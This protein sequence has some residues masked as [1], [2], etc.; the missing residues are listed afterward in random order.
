MTRKMIRFLDAA[1]VTIA[2]IFSTVGSRILAADEYPIRPITLVVPM[3]SGASTDIVARML[4]QE[5][6]GRLGKPV[7][8]ENKTGA[9][10]TI[11]TNY[12]ATSKPDGYTLLMVGSSFAANATI[13]KSLPYNVRTDFVPIAMVAEIP[14]ALLVNN[15][16][17]IATT[18]DLIAYAKKNPNKLNMATAGIGTPHHLFGELFS[19]MAGIKLT[20]VPYRGSLPGLNDVLSGSV[21]LMFCDLPPAKGMLESGKI[22]ALGVTSS[23]RVP[24]LPAVP[25]IGERDVPN[26][27]AVAWFTLLAPARTP[28]AV[29]ERLH[30][31]IKVIL[32]EQEMKDR[33][34]RMSLAPMRS[35]SLSEMQAFMNSEINR[36]GEVV[37]NAGIA[38]SQ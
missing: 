38:F 14:F 5:L 28:P 12:V 33:I 15:D 37:R 7:V 6:G 13:Y 30:R 3:A 27:Q 10:S 34:L 32:D 19:T 25:A 22:R 16:R 23:S 9:G 8:V 4:A 11:G 29:V 36:W 24:M 17:P 21:D 2:M 31:E 1:I 20:Q 26:Y 35:P 18:A